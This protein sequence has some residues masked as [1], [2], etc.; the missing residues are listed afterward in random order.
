M[1]CFDTRPEARRKHTSVEEHRQYVNVSGVRRLL[2]YEQR[3]VARHVE[4][5]SLDRST[6]SL[7]AAQKA[8]PGLHARQQ[9]APGGND[10]DTH[11]M[12][13]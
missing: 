13:T 12:K 4:R 7:R 2:A 5:R 10:H 8:R 9:I 11:E 1:H 6:L 3:K